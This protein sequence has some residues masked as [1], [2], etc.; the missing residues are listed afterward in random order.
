MGRDGPPGWGVYGGFAELGGCGWVDGKFTALGSKWSEG[1][2][3][4]H[5]EWPP[6]LGTC[7]VLAAGLLRMIARVGGQLGGP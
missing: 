1:L 2:L 6:Y 7:S 3:S 5:G 4:L